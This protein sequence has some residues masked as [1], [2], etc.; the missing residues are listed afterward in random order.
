M[1]KNFKYLLCLSVGLLACIQG[2]A[3]P[4]DTTM[5]GKRPKVG[6]V[7]SGGGAKGFAHLGAI[8]V[9]EDAGI[10]ID[11]IGGT[12]IG[13]IVGGLYAAGWTTEQIDSLIQDFDMMKLVQDKAERQYRLYYDKQTEGRIWFRLGMKKFKL[14]FPSAI[15]HGQNIINM[16]ADWTVPVHD[17]TDFDSLYIPYF[18]KATDLSHGTS[19]KLDKGYLPEAMRASGTFP[20]LLTPFEI[21]STVYVDGGVLDNYPVD[22]MREMGADIVIGININSGLSSSE[23]LGSI[24]GILDQI[25]GFQI[26]RNVEAQRKNVDLEIKPDI[27]EFNV[28]SFDAADSI[29]ERGVIAAEAQAAVLDKIAQ[30]QKGCDI[31][32]RTRPQVNP[33]EGFL[34]EDLQI[35]GTREYTK[36]YFMGRFDKDFPDSVTLDDI[37]RAVSRLYATDNFENVYY[38]LR[39]GSAPGRH[40]LN[41]IVVENPVHQYVGVSWGYDRLYGINLLLNLRINNILRRS[42]FETDL[43]IGESPSLWMSLFRDNGSRPSL[44]VNFKVGRLTTQTNFMDIIG[45][46]GEQIPFKLRTD[47]ASDYVQANIYAQTIIN[48]KYTVGLGVEYLYMKSSIDNFSYVGAGSLNFENT[49]FFSPNVYFSGDTRDDKFFPTR[50]FYFNAMYKILLSPK[51][52]PGDYIVEPSRGDFPSFITAEVEQSIRL[53][54][55]FA[56]TV[57]GYAGLSMSGKLPFAYR[58]F[59]GGVRSTMPFNYVQFYGLPFMWNNDETTTDLG[60][61]NLI[62]AS[63][64]LQYSPG[65]NQYIFAAYN[66]GLTSADRSAFKAKY[67]KISGMGAGYSI[68]TPIGKLQL[69][70]TYSPDKKTGSNFGV[71]FSAGYTF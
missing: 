2:F 71:F 60:Q 14:Q 20:S 70:G 57:G 17:V 69:V 56:L 8:K 13:A 7:L 32:E 41:L 33:T 35:S 44:G 52:K 42:I 31:P 11:Y 49:Y 64:K 4:A 37:H 19:V 47:I 55:Y 65:R 39:K 26:V 38:R 36:E 34:I 59:P 45:G 67:E 6:L 48:Q 29:Y 61:N 23:K 63:V 9:I 58:Y 18:A 30:M 25:I 16:F 12:S 10:H 1:K 53:S 27:A 24:V 40:V 28:M 51:A 21:D 62:K 43:V 50:G 15:S 3:N 54:K 66:Y 5:H 22:Q 68:G 46:S